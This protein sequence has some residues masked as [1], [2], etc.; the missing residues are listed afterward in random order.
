VIAGRKSSGRAKW[1][2]IS[3]VLL[4]LF[5]GVVVRYK[6]EEDRVNEGRR[7]AEAQAVETER[8][9]KAAAAAEADRQQKAEE[10]ARKRSNGNA[11]ADRK[12]KEAAAAEIERQQ[13]EAA[14]EVE[15]QQ[16]EAAAAAAAAAAKQREQK[17]VA[18]SK[19]LSNRYAGWLAKRGQEMAPQVITVTL[20]NACT[21]GP[22]WIAM[23]FKMPDETGRWMT[24]GWWK[25]DPGKTVRPKMATADH[26]VYFWAKDALGTWDGAK[27]P[28]SVTV[29][30][31]SN[32]F[33]HLDGTEIEGKEKKNV[34]MFPNVFKSWG[35]HTVGFTCN[36]RH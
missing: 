26:K 12:R 7:L 13:V 16:K 2:A 6:M 22:M 8:Q 21:S 9:R 15:R 1:I 29:P 11:E 33:V 28:G 23:R 30:V 31:V 27:D 34:V 35:D 24:S 32:D 17:A 36:N 25:V 20:K 14:A 3:A 10:A 4:A 18:N 19:D 5:A